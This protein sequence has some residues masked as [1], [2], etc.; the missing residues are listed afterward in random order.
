MRLI[1]LGLE[2]LESRRLRVDLLLV[3]KIV[4]FG[5]TGLR[6]EDF[7]RINVSRSILNLREYPYQSIQVN[8]YQS[9][10]SDVAEKSVSNTFLST[11]W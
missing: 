9:S 4:V 6:S 5:L 10:Q 3:Y 7:F 1:C 11:E 2:S 8:Q